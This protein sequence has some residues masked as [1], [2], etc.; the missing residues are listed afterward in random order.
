NATGLGNST[1]YVGP[2]AGQWATSG[3]AVLQ[4]TARGFGDSCGAQARTNETPAHYASVCSKGYIRLD[5]ERYEAHDI[6]W[7]AGLLADQGLANP[8]AI[9]VTGPS[10]G[11]G[12]SLELATLKDRVM[13]PNGTLS[14]WRSPAGKP[15][16]IAAAAPVIPWSDLAYSL[17]PNGGTLDYRLTGASTDLSPFGIEKQSFEGGLYALGQVNGYYSA[18]GTDPQA[19]LTTWYATVNMGEPYGNEATFIANQIAQFH[20]PFY[21]LDGKYGAPLEAPAPLLIAN[22][23]TDDLFPVDE[24]LRYSNLEHALYPSDPIQ[25]VDGDFG[26][27]RAQNKQG[28]VALLSGRIKAMFD[29]YLKRSGSAPRSNVTATIE[30]CP[31]SA[32]SGGPFS[33]STWAGLHP[34]EVYFASTLSQTV[35]SGAGSPSIS[36][37]IDPVAGP[38]ACATVTATDQGAGVATYRLPAVTGTGYTLLGSPTVVAKLSL[39]GSY[40]ELAGR[41]WDVNPSTNTETLVARGLYRPNASGMQVL[42]LHPGAWHFA[43][44]HIPKLEL[45]AQDSPYGRTSN[46]SFSISVSGLQLRLPVHEAPGTASGVGSPFPAVILGCSGLPRVH[47]SSVSGLRIRG[48]ASDTACPADGHTLSSREHVAHVYLIVYRASNRRRNPTTL[49][50]AGTSHWTLQLHSRL[51]HGRYIVFADAVDALG[52][53]Q[54]TTTSTTVQIR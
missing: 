29:N 15:L 48:T 54:L 47:I 1:A 37:A 6:Q 38:G 14:P 52:Q 53:H 30:T 27:M 36:E 25:L 50:A 19:D 9:G 18:P 33:A 45:L 24:A 8:S 16:R 28:D 44:G 40:P 43:A 31:S 23:F 46:G 26:H 21:L 34:G 39:S 41:L 3:Y 7:A 42:Q 10:Y 2:G 51:P 32:R 13:N 22:G 17:E 11:G 4:L 20:S 12:V 5:D 49:R 35:T